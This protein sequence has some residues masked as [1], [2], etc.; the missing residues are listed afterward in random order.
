MNH[1]LDFSE[2]NVDEMKK[3]IGQK[4]EAFSD[5]FSAFSEDSLEND[6]A[7]DDQVCK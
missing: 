2:E 3:C 7:I 4:K 6:Q 1:S 5:C